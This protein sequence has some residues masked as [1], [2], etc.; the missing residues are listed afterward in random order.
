MKHKIL[1]IL[2]LLPVDVFSFNFKNLLDLY[3]PISEKVDID[4]TIEETIN[5]RKPLSISGIPREHEKNV[6]FWRD[7]YSYFDSKHILIHSKKDL[8]NV[9]MVVNLTNLYKLE[10]RPIVAEIKKNRI[11]RKKV[12]DVKDEINKCYLGNKCK[13]KL[14][15]KISQNSL[16]RSLRTQT[17]QLDILK[18]GVKRFQVYK[19]SIYEIIKNTNSNPEW[20]AIPFLE[21]S[22]N[23]KAISKVGATGA[24]QIMS[25]VGKRMMPI[26]K[27][28]DTRKNPVISAYAGLKILRENR[29]ITK[30]EDIAIISYNSGLRN[31]FL[32]KKKFKKSKFKTNEYLK[33]SRSKNKNFNFASENFLLEYYAMKEFLTQQGIISKNNKRN[34]SSLNKKLYTPYISRCKTRPSKIISLL[35]KHGKNAAL[36]NNHFRKKYLN[37]VLP[38]GQIYMSNVKLPNKF[39]KKIT[40]KK[41]DDMSP[42]SWKANHRNCSI[43]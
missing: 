21:S 9:F 20:I 2:F 25:Y 31:Y 15:K 16:Y 37:K 8:G 38:A 12:Q 18:K 39:Y 29:I 4:L 14:N 33:L 3:I 10:S 1:L 43:I 27:Y 23:S 30:N 42:I 5:Y 13:Y 36:N 24:W 41:L 19:N 28:M 32:L 11:M 22:F 35:S 34:I 17:G 40:A 26:N 6:M 7:I